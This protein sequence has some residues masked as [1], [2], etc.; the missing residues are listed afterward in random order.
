MYQQWSGKLHY[1]R[2]TCNL[3]FVFLVTTAIRI[4]LLN[5]NLELMTYWRK[6]LG[7]TPEQIFVSYYVNKH[8]TSLEENCKQWPCSHKD[9]HQHNPI[10]HLYPWQLPL[11]TFN[12]VTTKIILPTHNVRE[13]Y[14]QKGINIYQTVASDP[15]TSRTGHTSITQQVPPFSPER[16]P[17]P[18]LH[19]TTHTNSPT[20]QI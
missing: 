16:H 12:P 9:T 2:V 19:H 3:T 18:H 1:H 20:A 6:K 11:L 17:R 14:H 8:L 13:I 10:L 15:N 7:Q 4:L 5:N